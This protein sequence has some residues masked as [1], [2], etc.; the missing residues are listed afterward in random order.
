MASPSETRFRVP[1]TTRVLALLG[2]DLAILPTNWADKA[3]KTSGLM[4]KARALENHI[5]FAAVDRVG[6]ESGFHYIGQS[7]LIDFNGD[8][9]DSAEHDRDAILYAVIDPAAARSKLVVNIPAEYEIDRVNWRRPDMYGPLLDGSVFK[10]H[11]NN[12]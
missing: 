8:V 1:E 3:M 6:T 7:S 9:L 11:R 12:G 10:G 4:P 2:A 5:Y